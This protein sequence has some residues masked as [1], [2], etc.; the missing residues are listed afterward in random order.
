MGAARHRDFFTPRRLPPTSGL[1]PRPPGTGT[2][3]PATPPE[4]SRTT[5]RWP[6]AFAHSRPKLHIGSC[7]IHVEP[8]ASGSR[9]IGVLMNLAGHH[10]FRAHIHNTRLQNQ[11]S[12]GATRWL[13][14]HRSLPLL[15]ILGRERLVTLRMSFYGP[16]F[17]PLPRM[18]SRS[19]SHSLK[20][21]LCAIEGLAADFGCMLGAAFPRPLRHRQGIFQLI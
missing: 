9:C 8:P 17:P 7:G 16:V 4:S 3:W 15:G 20:D 11:P 10:G 13:F 18:S 12:P 14:I 1:V 19:E 6:T 2:C 21:S 5:R